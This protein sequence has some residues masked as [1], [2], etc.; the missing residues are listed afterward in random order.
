MI[1]LIRQGTQKVYLNLNKVND[2]DF[3]SVVFLSPSRP[4][5]ELEKSLVEV[6]KGS[7]YFEITEEEISLI[8]DNSYYYEV[9]KDTEKLKVGIVTVTE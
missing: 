6:N 9:S 2:N 3:V 4:K 8:K 5:I 7:F 1:T